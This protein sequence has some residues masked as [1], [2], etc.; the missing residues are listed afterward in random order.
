MN[1][2]KLDLNLLVYL[3]VLLRERN[4]TRAAEQLNIT[5]PAMSNGLKRLR[6]MLG[7]PILVRTSSGMEPTEY[8]T[9]IQPLLRAFIANAEEIVHN[10]DTFDAAR[11]NRV[12]RIMASD[13]AESTLLPAVLGKLSRQASDIVLDVLTPSDVVFEDIEHG[14]VDMA[15]N[16]F[17]EMPQSLHQQT[18]WQ[19]TFS[20]LMSTSNKASE[21]WSL[22][23]YLNA[24]HVWVSKTGMGIG[25]GMSPDRIQRLGWVD[26]ALSQLG[27]RRKI[28]VF[29]RHYQVAGLLAGQDDLIITLPTRAAN[30][31]QNSADVVALT[32]P[33]NI[34]PISLTMAW[35]PLLQH[36]AAH[37]WLRKLIVATASE[38]STDSN[39]QVT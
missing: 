1:L 12:F 10:K 26:E 33:F 25:V 11:S 15:I 30:L 20:C 19:D 5:Q 16:R 22:A 27:A 17:D 9:E 21:D 32:P 31:H 37:K 3:E 7:D 14:R 13:Y 24:R 4:V 18:L 8:A 35:G 28:K 23:T 29:T 38:L 36:N 6:T 39:S 2:A 34:E